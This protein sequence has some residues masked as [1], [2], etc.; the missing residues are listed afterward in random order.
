MVRK[1]IHSQTLASDGVASVVKMLH[2][3][4]T[5]WWRGRP[6]L[7][8]MASLTRGHPTGHSLYPQRV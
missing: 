5:F 6:I 3:P 4:T 7:L 2:L 8:Q 1:G